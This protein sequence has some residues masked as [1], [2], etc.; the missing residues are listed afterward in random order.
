MGLKS[1][2]CRD[3]MLQVLDGQNCFPSIITSYK[4]ILMKFSRN[5]EMNQGTD[6][7][8]LETFRNPKVL[9]SAK[10]KGLWL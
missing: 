10:A 2:Q 9:R 4:Q 6:D 1:W 7:Y 3:I 8:I 5:V